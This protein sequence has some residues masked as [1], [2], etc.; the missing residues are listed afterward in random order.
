MKPLKHTL[1]FLLTLAI[2]L[3][4]TGCGPSAE[5][6]YLTNFNERFTAYSVAMEQAAAQFKGTDPSILEDQA[7]VDATIATLDNLDAVGQTLASTPVEDVPEKF[8]ALDQLLVDISDQTTVFT[9]AMKDGL[10]SGD[11]DAMLAALDEL[12][13]ILGL[14][15]QAQAEL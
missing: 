3:T 1:F 2:A 12:E 9:T 15:Q 6:V 13:A 4:M 10:V 5:E 7:W 14:V 8:T 11:K